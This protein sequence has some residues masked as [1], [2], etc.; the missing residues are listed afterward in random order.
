MDDQK[1]VLLKDNE[2][3]LDIFNWFFRLLVVRDGLFENLILKEFPSRITGMKGKGP[4]GLKGVEP[5]KSNS[6]LMR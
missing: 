3:I 5:G 6:I 4:A 1:R 2:I